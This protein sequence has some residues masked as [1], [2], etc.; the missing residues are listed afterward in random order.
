MY[1]KL[2]NNIIMNQFSTETIGKPNPRNQKRAANM[3]TINT[4]THPKKKKTNW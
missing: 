2:G 3:P 1:S 4:F